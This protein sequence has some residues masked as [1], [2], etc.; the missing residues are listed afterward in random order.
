MKVRKFT[1]IIVRRMLAVP[2]AALA[3]IILETSFARF[4]ASIATFSE[5][6][7]P[8]RPFGRWKL[9]VMGE[10]QGSCKRAAQR[11]RENANST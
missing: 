2:N 4:R 10:T 8:S 9:A 3:G 5:E 11:I 7:T 1:R 6:G